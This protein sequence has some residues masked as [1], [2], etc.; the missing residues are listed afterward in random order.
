MA[1]DVVKIGEEIL[2]KKK[3]ANISHA[4]SNVDQT[5]VVREYPYI[6]AE[7]V[8][9][10][11]YEW[12]C[13]PEDVVCRRTRLAFLNKEAALSAVPRVAEIMGAELGWGADR[14]RLEAEQCAAYIDRSFAG[15]T[16]RDE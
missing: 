12:A 7:V 3:G 15:A 11:R 9:A 1:Q 10:V 8:Y 6:E 2:A 14:V 16:P 4:S 5:L 13:K